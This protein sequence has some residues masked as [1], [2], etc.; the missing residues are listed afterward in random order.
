MREL[1]SEHDHHYTSR[2]TPEY[3]VTGIQ[4]TAEEAAIFKPF[5]DFIAQRRA[6][7]DASE[8][9]FLEYILSQRKAPNGSN[10]TPTANSPTVATQHAPSS[11]DAASRQPSGPSNSSPNS[12]SCDGQPCRAESANGHAA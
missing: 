3:Q 9:W 1:H 5:H 8:K 6:E 4:L 10:A 7:I 2:E 11:H 12:D